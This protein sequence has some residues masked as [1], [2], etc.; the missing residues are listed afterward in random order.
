MDGS[1]EEQQPLGMAEGMPIPFQLP[2]GDQEV[3]RAGAGEVGEG[4]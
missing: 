4:V 2:A 3:V 1:P